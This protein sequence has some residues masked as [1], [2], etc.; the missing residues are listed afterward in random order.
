MKIYISG[1]ISRD[2]DYKN[3]FA[4]A[5]ELVREAGHIPFNPSLKPK[6]FTYKR[7]I[8]MSLNELS[9]CDAILLLRGWQQSKGACLEKH[10]AKAIG[11]RIL[12]ECDFIA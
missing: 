12:K 11:M 1:S 4:A 2:P 3:K 8:D 6:G 7:Y 10:Y 9:N 5:E